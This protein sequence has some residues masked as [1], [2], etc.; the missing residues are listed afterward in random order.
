MMVPVSLEI[1]QRFDLFL[2][3]RQLAFEGLIVGGAAFMLLGARDAT[4]EDVD[5]I[6]QIPGPIRNASEEF[7]KQ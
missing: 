5:F 7:A 1:N 2:Q 4:T 6:T 3:P